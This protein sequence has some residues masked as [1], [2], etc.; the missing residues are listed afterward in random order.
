[1]KLSE[2]QRKD[3][4]DIKTGKKIGKIVDV[5]FDQT[6]GYMIKFIIEKEHF[7]KNLFLSSEE[8]TIKFTQIK[9]MGEDVILIDIN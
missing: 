3:I 4:V 1:M 2:L 6:N 8:L 7:I 5:E 9:K